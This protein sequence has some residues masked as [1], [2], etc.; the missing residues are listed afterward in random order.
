MEYIHKVNNRNKYI[1]I[2]FC[3]ILYQNSVFEM[4]ILNASET[5][6]KKVMI[7][8]VCCN[9]F[10]FPKTQACVLSVGI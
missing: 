6:D 1:Y 3:V 4:N 10:D 8:I 7:A 9:Q 2:T 5:G